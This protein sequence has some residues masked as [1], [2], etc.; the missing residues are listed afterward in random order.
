M[1]VFLVISLPKILYTHRIY[2]VLANPIDTLFLSK[3]HSQPEQLS[4]DDSWYCE[5][6]TLNVPLTFYITANTLLLSK[7]PPRPE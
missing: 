4:K 2:V 3:T 5:H 7:T 1:A 6:C